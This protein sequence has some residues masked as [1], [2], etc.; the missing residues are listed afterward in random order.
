MAEKKK[1]FRAGL[2]AVIVGVIL[3]VVLTAMTIFAFT[4]RYTGFK[5][6]KVARQYVDTIVQTGDGYN[7]YKNTLV[8]KNQKYGNFIVNAYMAPYVN[9]GEDV[10]QAD[11]VGTGS[12]EEQEAI[13]KVYNTMY[14]YYVDLVKNIGWDDYDTFFNSYFSK[15]KEIRHGVYGDDYL[16]TEYMFGALEANVDTY[17]ESLTGAEETLADDGKTVVKEAF[18]GKYAE[19]FGKDYK[20]TAEVTECK[21]LN[22]DESVAYIQEYAARI[23]DVATLDA[24]ELSESGLTDDEA[25]KNM[26]EAFAKLDCSELI[27]N[28][29]EATVEVKDQNGKTVAT[30]KV[31]VVKIDSGWYVDN[32]NIDTSGLYLA[33]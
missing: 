29:A 23:T 4:T 21:E 12:A 33:K 19:L 1:G 18:D 14:D 8:S 16:D 2:Y 32:T 27:S 7:A 10:K 22:H 17:G 13:D 24:N 20:L 26:T 11:F 25:K 28:V 15:L 5:P 6:D 3:A 31:Y 30:Q 9:D